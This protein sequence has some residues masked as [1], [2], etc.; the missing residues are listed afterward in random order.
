MGFSP[1]LMPQGPTGAS[2]DSLSAGAPQVAKPCSDDGHLKINH[3]FSSKVFLASYLRVAAV[4]VA[5]LA[6][7]YWLLRCFNQMRLAQKLGGSSRALAG[8]R[9]IECFLAQ[10]S[11]SEE[12]EENEEVGST[13][14]YQGP[15][16]QPADYS[17]RRRESAVPPAMR[18]THSPMKSSE[19]AKM[20]QLQE[21][22]ATAHLQSPSPWVLQPYWQVA[23][24]LQ[25]QAEY[26][27]NQMHL[28]VESAASP[29]LEAFYAQ[30]P[31]SQGAYPYNQDFPLLYPEGLNSQDEEHFP[32][33]ANSQG[34]YPYNLDFPLLYPEGLNSQDEEHFP[35]FPSP[36][37]LYFV[38]DYAAYSL[39]EES[40]FLEPGS[41]GEQPYARFLDMEGSEQQAASVSGSSIAPYRPGVNNTGNERKGGRSQRSV[42]SGLPALY[43]GEKM[44]DWAGRGMPK[45]ARV[46]V[47]N[48][49]DWMRK[50]AVM[51]STL[52]P[53]LGANQGLRLSLV[54]GK[55]LAMSLGVFSLLPGDL[56]H[57]RASTGKDILE[58]LGSAETYGSSD[59]EMKPWCKNVRTLRMLVKDLKLPRPQSEVVGPRKRR[60]RTLNMMGSIRVVSKYCSNMLWQIPKFVQSASKEEMESAVEQMITISNVLWEM[61]K[62]HV[63]RDRLHRRYIL[64]CQTRTNIWIL[65]SR[66]DLISGEFKPFTPYKVFEAQVHDA[67]SNAGGLP[68]PPDDFHARAGGMRDAGSHLPT[69]QL[70]TNSSG[71]PTHTTEHTIGSYNMQVGLSN[72]PFQPPRSA[73]A[74]S[75][76]S[77]TSRS[78]S[79]RRHPKGQNKYRTVEHRQP[80]NTQP[81]PQTFS[82]SGSSEVLQPPRARLPQTFAEPGLYGGP[83]TQR[84]RR[85][86]DRFDQAPPQASPSDGI[87][88]RAN[89]LM[90]AAFRP[91]QTENSFIAAFMSMEEPENAA[92][93]TFTVPGGE[94]GP[95]QWQVSGDRFPDL[96]PP[97]SQD[98]RSGWPQPDD[99]RGNGS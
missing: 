80:P 1:G 47:T 95:R 92:T 12:E 51:C 79:R 32:Y 54:M 2:L 34:A 10:E 55:I 41:Q 31:D 97:P 75:N 45:V 33:F 49:L 72:W 61:L 42:A 35:Y 26:F 48:I 83:S 73:I 85:Q 18:P 22:G 86:M 40:N 81:N 50:T 70:P 38:S 69:D 56:E 66:A 44:E 7:V 28:Q 16:Q 11:D 6:V 53:L 82:P 30:N 96:S 25:A 87:Q 93:G 88:H 36:E 20:F 78:R 63:N 15:S 62:P 57:W 52:L 98:H 24:E 59:P 14:H 58:L 37:P 39:V 4:A 90:G 77:R 46:Q 68:R 13:R 17:V 8:E 64:D 27:Q 94:R 74:T 76:R 29:Y 23:P 60:S 5:S 99:D 84:V 71:G 43:P 9:D 89:Q 3:M 91:R 65:L 19:A 67:V 21:K